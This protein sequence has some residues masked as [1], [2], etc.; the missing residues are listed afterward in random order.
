MT[1]S[2]ILTGGIDV[3]TDRI[4]VEIVDWIPL[5]V[6]LRVVEPWDGDDTFVAFQRHMHR[7]IEEAFG[8]KP[9]HQGRK[10]CLSCGAIQTV[11]GVLPCGH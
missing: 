10:T 7:Q 4:E 1:Q 8:I 11:D 6:V 3:A 2:S 9:I 5:E